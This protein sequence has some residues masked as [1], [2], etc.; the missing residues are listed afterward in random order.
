MKPREIIT[1]IDIPSEALIENIKR[2]LSTYKKSDLDLLFS[3]EPHLQWDNVRIQGNKLVIER[4]AK[5]FDKISRYRNVSGTIE[6][7]IIA[8]NEKT[9][10][11]SR[12]TLDTAM[13]TFLKYVVGIAI[14]VI[15]T[16]WLVLDFNYFL[17][18]VLVLFE[19]F[20]FG[21]IPIIQ[22]EY[23]DDLTDYYNSVI[24]ALSNR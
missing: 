8:D 13:A 24:R 19:G 11:K 16:S 9:I 15:G 18:F 22:R 23:L 21:V 6:C 7:E 17:L 20:I 4:S 10:L 12:I 3:V 5:P 1:E 14:A 2:K